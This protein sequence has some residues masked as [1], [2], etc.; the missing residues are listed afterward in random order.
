[1]RLI[2][3]IFF[4]LVFVAPVLRAA[5]NPP[6]EKGFIYQDHG[7]RDPFWPLVSSTGNAINYDSDLSVTDMTLEGIVLNENGDAIAM[8]NGKVVK[9]GDRVGE[10][11]VDS[12][13]K[14]LVVFSKGEEKFELKLKKK[15]E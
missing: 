9:K 10:F 8:I 4:S 1:M 7:K 5:E 2:A 12:I 3:I 11:M 15:E 14:T 13:E 6:E